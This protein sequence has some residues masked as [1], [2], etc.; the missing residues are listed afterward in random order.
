[1]DLISHWSLKAN[2][3]V[4]GICGCRNVN[5]WCFHVDKSLEE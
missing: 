1:M 2:F 4:V 3:V 5:R